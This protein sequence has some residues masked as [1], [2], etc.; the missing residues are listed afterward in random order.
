LSDQ[1]TTSN[2]IEIAI[3]KSQ[4]HLL[5]IQAKESQRVPNRAL[6]ERGD[7]QVA[8][9]L[10]EN[11]GAARFSERAYT[12]LVEQPEVD[13][14]LLEKIALRN[15]IPLHISRRLLERVTLAVRKRIWRWLRRKNEMTSPICWPAF[16]IKLLKTKNWIMILLPRSVLSS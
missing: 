4:F 13:E 3:A 6:I 15:D 12:H 10:A 1:L 14:T 8:S 2:F 11:P 7:R 9:T 5:A 16:E